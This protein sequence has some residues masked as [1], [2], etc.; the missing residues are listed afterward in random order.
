MLVASYVFY[1]YW[2]W[3]FLGLLFAAT[4]VDYYVSTRMADTQSK[5][6]RRRL[7]VLS[8]VA[9]LTFLGFFKYYGFFVRELGELLTSLG[10]Q[11]HFPVL[12]I[13]LPVGISFYTFQ[14]DE[15]HDRCVSRA[16]QAGE[17]FFNFALFVSYFPQLVAGPIERPA[18]P[19]S[20]RS[21]ASGSTGTVT[22]RKASIMCWWLFKKVVLADNVALIANHVFDSSRTGLPA[23]E[24]VVGVLA[25]S[26]QIYGD[27]SGYSSI[28]QG[29]SRWMGIGL[30]Y[31][32][33]MPYFSRSPSEFWQRWHISLSSWL[34]DYLYISLGGNR[35]GNMRTYVNLMLT[36]LLGGLWH[37]ASW[38]FVFWGAWHG[39]LL[40]GYR[41]AGVETI[42]D[43]QGRIACGLCL[44]GRLM[45]ALVC[46]G[47][48]FFRA[49]SL[50]QAL[51]MIASLAG[52][53]RP[54]E[55]S[56]YAAGLLLFFAAPLLVFEWLVYRAGDMLLFLRQSRFVQYLGYAYLLV[57][58]MVFP[59]LTQQIFIYFQF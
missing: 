30:S 47:W 27:F 16:H 34:R 45:F 25:F 35:R 9:N 13:I 7:I 51:D 11:P 46:I 31:N 26:L 6:R 33:R 48:I 15:L 5:S 43:A 40:V 29:V 38:T 10:F 1:G 17:D 50:A 37:G 22:S 52:S 32:F 18:R 55:Y 49:D 59:P 14:S 8:V 41:M 2:D 12:K 36:M 53:Y 39:L 21:K 28:A 57:M 54:T 19:A 56:A 20:H 4:L 3:K 23:V 44:P 42:G 24:V 58:L